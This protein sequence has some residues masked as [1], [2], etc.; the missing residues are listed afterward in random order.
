M[1]FKYKY[2]THISDLHIFGPTIENI[3][4][5]FS[6]LIKTIKKDT[7]L[8]I[9]GDIFEFKTHASDNDIK[10]FRTLCQQ[11]YDAKVQCV[12]IP[13]NH[14]YNDNKALWIDE[15]PS[16]THPDLVTLLLD[17]KYSPYISCYPDS[18]VYT[19][20]NIDF[21][22]FSPIDNKIPAIKPS[23]NFRVALIHEPVYGA[24]FYNGIKIDDA[25]FQVSDLKKFDIACLGDIHKPQ[26]LA[27][28]VGYSGSFVQKNLGE[29]LNHGYIKWDLKKKVG[30]FT[31]IPL[32]Q[33]KL[34]L[35]I[36]NDQKPDL[37]LS[38]KLFMDAMKYFAVEYKDCSPE[39]I[40]EFEQTIK[41]TGNQ[42]DMIRYKTQKTDVKNVDPAQIFEEF[43]EQSFPTNKDN[44]MDLHK[45][46]LCEDNRCF[47]KWGLK[48]LKWEN[49][50]TYGR[51]NYIDFEQ[52][53]NLAFIIGKNKIGKSF[54]ID[55]LIWLLYN[56]QLR[57][58][59]KYMLN[60]E[61]KDVYGWGACC[62][63]VGKHEY[64]IERV[65]NIKRNCLIKLTRDGEVITG[66]DVR[67]T[68][69]IMQEL[70]G[71]HHDFTTISVALQNRVSFVD[72]VPRERANFICKFLGLDILSAIEKKIKEKLRKLKTTLKVT[73][74]AVVEKPSD[75]LLEEIE[76]DKKEVEKLGFDRKELLDRKE[77]LLK[78]CQNVKALTDS[79]M[80]L[81][82]KYKGQK[83]ELSEENYLQVVTD[84]QSATT[85]L[86][87]I[88]WELKKTKKELDLH[89]KNVQQYSGY[90]KVEVTE[91]IPNLDKLRLEITSVE[92][93]EGDFDLTTLIR[94][95]D[96]L[97]KE[98]VGT[99]LFKVPSDSKII[100]LTSTR[101]HCKEKVKKLT[102]KIDA[103][104]RYVVPV[105]NVTR[106]LEFS[107]SC[108]KCAHNK[109]TLGI[110]QLEINRK[111]E[112]RINKLDILVSKW[113]SMLVQLDVNEKLLHNDKVNKLLDCEK[114]IQYVQN[115]VKL[116]E[117]AK[118][119]G[120]EKQLKFN[121]MCDVI[122]KLQA[123]VTDLQGKET[124]VERGL[125]ESTEKIRIH[126][127]L[128][129]WTLLNKNKKLMKEIN[130]VKT[131][132][133]S[134]EDKLKT[135]TRNVTD[136][137]VKYKTES[138]AFEVFQENDKL[139]QT[140][141]KRYELLRMYACCLDQKKGVP[142]KILK[143]IRGKLVDECNEFLDKVTDFNIT[144]EFTDN[145]YEISTTGRNKPIPASMAS[146]FQK[147]IID[148][149]IRVA[150]SK[151]CNIPL[152]NI[153]IVDEGFGCSDMENL[154]V[155]R[156]TLPNL[157]QCYD[158]VLI[159]SHVE[160]LKSTAKHSIVVDVD[161]KISTVKY[162][163]IT[164]ST[165]LIEKK[166]KV[167]KSG[168]ELSKAV[169]V[170]DDNIVMLENTWT[171]KVCRKSY[172]HRKNAIKKHLE[173][174]SHR[175][176]LTAFSLRSKT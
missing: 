69:N 161:R 133:D 54:I 134:L 49:L 129:R 98:N 75:T 105:K 76:E 18:G 89:Q 151:V 46:Y 63:K 83:V 158:F 162:G 53:D 51:D 36:Q 68:Y 4:H 167:E 26:F 79:E 66:K 147:F 32:K 126:D 34:K 93:L 31:A 101:E 58:Q 87:K 78:Q 94:E 72:L 92:V 153:L 170:L 19:H 47:N 150:V 30:K 44:L 131:L 117:L 130:E 165:T 81:V 125:V 37:Q 12:M 118:W 13:G 168:K 90:S 38:D 121:T 116:D 88:T 91:E 65:I 127:V 82:N 152:P 96:V 139:A 61:T 70:I 15:T 27:P 136:K 45:K 115:K 77:E 137:T 128:T 16:T 17:S 155:L 159:I 14:D 25:R 33:F 145:G 110:E 60:T 67:E 52:L 20:N 164:Y 163:D 8:V 5:A 55:I 149:S 28:N 24:E 86:E 50:F 1:D 124:V 154:T 84:A 140:R 43:V 85:K 10:C 74:C 3:Y 174:N 146:G 108:D 112:E 40:C 64:I 111:C 169:E 71:N 56:V 41:D 120:I 148:L 42:I 102:D 109:K 39:F 141:R 114:K 7:I 2:I 138:A 57:G 48:W 95:R 23:K 11:I 62:F 172:K 22:V 173:S 156:D 9:T 171:C 119:E 99:S 21:Y 166:E 143:I 29:D 106:N 176:L 80:K 100:A 132:I 107:T 73:A 104:K 175:G 123:K 97:L 113:K 157:A 6:V 122:D 103:L 135:L 160:T 59:Q 142:A 144:M 35:Q